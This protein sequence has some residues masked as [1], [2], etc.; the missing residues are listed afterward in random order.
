MYFPA[1]RLFVVYRLSYGLT[2][3]SSIF[4]TLDGPKATITYH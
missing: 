4:S 1:L 2:Q 3:L